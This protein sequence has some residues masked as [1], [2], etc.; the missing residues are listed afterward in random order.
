[1]FGEGPTEVP[2]QDPIVRCVVQCLPI[3]DCGMGLGHTHKDTLGG[4]GEGEGEGE[5][6]GRGRSKVNREGRARG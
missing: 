2:H 1:M 5:G 3:I 4:G 6:R